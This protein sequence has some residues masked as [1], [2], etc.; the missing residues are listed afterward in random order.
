VIAWR[1]AIGWLLAAA[2]FVVSFAFSYG[3]SSLRMSFPA[4]L[5]VSAG[6]AAA[7][8][9]SGV[10]PIAGLAVA[11][12]VTCALPVFDSTFDA[13][14]LVIVLVGFQASMRSTLPAWLLVIVVLGALTVNE[15]WTRWAFDRPFFEPSLINPALMTAL[16][17]GLGLQSRR[18]LEQNSELVRFHEE[19]KR[20]AVVDERRRIARDVHDVAAHHLSALVVRNQLAR[21]VG[22][23]Q[24][25]T[26]AADFSADT[27]G[28]ALESLRQVVRVLSA[29]DDAPLD[30]QPTFA[31]IDAVIER[32]RSA[33]LE[34][35]RRAGD[36][37][38]ATRDVQ[39]AVVRI[40]Q[41]ALAN[42][43]RHRGPGRAWLDL[44]V[45]GD[46][47]TLTVEDDGPATIG[48]G[49]LGTRRGV[50]GRGLIGMRE[51]A[52]ACGGRLTVGPSNRGGWRV[53][54]VLPMVRS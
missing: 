50:E 7:V 54:A 39:I 49:D 40:A 10:R 27:A 14:G 26:D 2:T 13:M 1:P 43:L 35:E 28:E 38:T 48:A 3:P 21:R 25:L 12:I 22:S 5:A 53:A 29:D 30:P 41:E 44:G 36:V 19:S 24:A 31:D 4:A 52:E 45:D 8:W 15:V 32:M 37:P 33:G 46:D 16:A 9:L 6:A 42:V 51:R 11:T 23:V 20:V 34:V 18:V 47:V 17:V